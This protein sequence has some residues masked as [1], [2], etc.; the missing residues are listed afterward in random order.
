MP[1]DAVY[2]G[3]A[4]ISQEAHHTNNQQATQHECRAHEKGDETT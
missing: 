4:Q 3:L 2:I 1:S